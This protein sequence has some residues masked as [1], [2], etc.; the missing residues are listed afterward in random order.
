MRVLALS[1]NAALGLG[2]FAFFLIFTGA[3]RPAHAADSH[4]AELI[5]VYRTSQTADVEH[6]EF[7]N[8]PACEA[9]LARLHELQINTW[10]DQVSGICVEY[11][12]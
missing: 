5:V 11:N 12:Q 7:G 2:L 1:V 8:M 6:F 3:L 4:S 10:V 9:A